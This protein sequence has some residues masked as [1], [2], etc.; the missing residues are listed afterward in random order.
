M[1]FTRTAALGGVTFAGVIVG[2][3]LILVPAGLPLHGATPEAVLRFFTET[4][5]VV[6]VAALLMP[7]AWVASTVFAAGVLVELSRTGAAA[8]GWSLI[9]FAGVL[10]QNAAFAGVVA[11]RV[12][13]ASATVLDEA[14]AEV[15]WRVHDALFTL[16]GTFLATALLGFSIGGRLGRLVPSW[17]AVLGV[18]AALLLFTSATLSFF[19][20]Q[21]AS[22]VGW[23]GLTGWLLWVAWIVGCA[24][25]LWRRPVG[26]ARPARSGE[27]SGGV[28]A[29]S[30]GETAGRGRYSTRRRQLH[31]RSAVGEEGGT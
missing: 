27:P 4:A 21:P 14:T 25:V 16:N 13:L 12:G 7:L 24:G 11:L 1:T 26:P 23:L 31:Q 29:P 5:D 20:I 18:G 10:L 30:A 22:P 9:G 28:A 17:H 3:N 19:V 15:V 6:G 2:A 8:L